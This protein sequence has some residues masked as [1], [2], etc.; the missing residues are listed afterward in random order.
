MMEEGFNFWNNW[1]NEVIN[2]QN[3]MFPANKSLN[4]NIKGGLGIWC[5]YGQ[6]TTRIIA[7]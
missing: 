3:V 6:S 7:K 1:Q 5:G 2:S 4:G